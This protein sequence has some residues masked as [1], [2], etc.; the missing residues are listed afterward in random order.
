MRQ[1][2]FR[3]QKSPARKESAQHFV[4]DVSRFLCRDRSTSRS[5][6]K[7]FFLLLVSNSV[8]PISNCIISV[9]SVRLLVRLPYGFLT[10]KL[11]GTENRNIVN[12]CKCRSSQPRSQFSVQN[13]EDQGHRTLLYFKKVAHISLI[14][15][16]GLVE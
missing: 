5:F 2:K 13:V 3:M 4:I 7:N 15:T 12:V 8:G 1:K 10:S 14:T 9:L 11:K 6:L 16:C